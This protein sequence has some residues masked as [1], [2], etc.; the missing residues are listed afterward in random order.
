MIGQL[1]VIL[2]DCDQD[3]SWKAPVHVSS[4]AFAELI[5]W[6]Q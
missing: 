1:S 5:F 3:G 4:G 2:Q 6:K